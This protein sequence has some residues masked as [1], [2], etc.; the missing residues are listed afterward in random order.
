MANIDPILKKAKNG[1]AYEWDSFVDDI[2][3]F[4]DNLEE[5]Y[6]TQIR[7]LEEKIAELESS[8]LN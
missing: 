2:Q 4:I 3:A 7:E 5:K 1:I 6:D 8:P